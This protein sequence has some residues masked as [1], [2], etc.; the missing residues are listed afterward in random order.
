M[1]PT[2]SFSLVTATLCVSIA[3]S[4]ASASQPAIEPASTVVP[5]D[6]PAGAPLL[7]AETLQLT[8]AVVHRIANT[9]STVEYVDLFAFDD[10]ASA[11]ASHMRRS[12]FCKTFPGDR[13]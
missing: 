12:G 5:F 8:D 4:Q 3:H 2:C 11:N 7:E 9:K 1:A 13:D 10:G 6:S